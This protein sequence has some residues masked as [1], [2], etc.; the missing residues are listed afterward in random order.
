MHYNYSL[1]IKLMTVCR[2]SVYYKHVMI[3]DGELADMIKNCI[4]SPDV[5]VAVDR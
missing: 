5:V 4:Y 3:N 2:T 1:M